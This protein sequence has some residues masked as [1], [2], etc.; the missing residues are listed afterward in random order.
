MYVCIYIY[1][2]VCVC[3]CVWSN[4]CLYVRRSSRN[5]RPNTL[6]PDQP[7][8]DRPAARV[9]AQQYSFTFS[10]CAFTVARNKFG[11]SLKKC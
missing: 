6:A 2:C 4:T 5:P 1:V 9:I 3:V 7:Q 10:Y 8:H 11:E